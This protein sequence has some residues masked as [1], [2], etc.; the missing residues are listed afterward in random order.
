V[1][2][3]DWLTEA[4]RATLQRYVDEMNAYR[5]R[6]R[7]EEPVWTE[8]TAVWALLRKTLGEKHREY[9]KQDAHHAALFTLGEGG[10]TPGRVKKG[11]DNG[12]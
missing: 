9:A 1:E 2:L 7:P 8:E 6:T 10:K 11:R 3:H 4:E 5:N 12:R